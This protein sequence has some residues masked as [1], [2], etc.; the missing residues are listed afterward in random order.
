MDPLTEGFEER[1]QEIE[2]YLEFLENLEAQVQQGPP[3]IGAN[4]PFITVQQQKI[5]YS[6]V[7]VQLYNLVE[8]TVSRCLNAVSE[9]AAR[10]GL[11]RPSDLA[12]A[13]RRD[14][15]RVTART[16][17]DLNPENRLNDAFAL[18]EH[19]LQKLPVNEWVITRGAGGSWDDTRIEQ[20]ADRLGLGLVIPGPI[21]TRVKRHFRNEQG[22]LVFIKTFRN[23]LAHGNVSFVEGG[24]NLSV[25]DLRELHEGTAHYL[26]EVVARFRAYIDGYE[27][28]LPDRRPT[29]AGGGNA[30]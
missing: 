3:R 26:R 10:D 24:E 23:H 13:L 7:F 28:L 2:T 17:E 4:G 15:V 30:S 27:F 12:D 18:C 29:A 19:L 5:L 16:H 14:W 20:L 9:A 8:S 1:L 22:T 25:T 6:S 21:S 11:W